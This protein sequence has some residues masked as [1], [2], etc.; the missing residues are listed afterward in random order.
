VRI[1]TAAPKQPTSAGGVSVPPSVPQH[2]VTP[3]PA[4]P[5]APHAHRERG[6]RGHKVSGGPAAV[7]A[8]HTDSTVAAAPAPAPAPTEGGATASATGVLSAPAPGTPQTRRGRPVI[9]IGRH[10]EAALS[11]AV[12][13]GGGGGGGERKRRGEKDRDREGGAADDASPAPSGPAGG[14]SSAPERKSTGGKHKDHHTSGGKHSKSAGAQPAV[15]N[16]L[17]RNDAQTVPGEVSIA[18]RPQSPRDAQSGHQADAPPVR[19]GGG[20]R[21]GRGRGRGG[22]R[23]G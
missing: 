6:H 4:P 12:G 14:G 16:I 2:S 20:G 3:T 9:G 10:F 13:S 19:G 1:Q 17:Q 18:Q 22:P 23:G 5:T 7:H 8:K 21:R 15:P 11:G